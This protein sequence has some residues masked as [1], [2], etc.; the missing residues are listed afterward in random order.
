MAP[1]VNC[2]GLICKLVS[3]RYTEAQTSTVDHA[4]KGVHV[5]PSIQTCNKDHA[6]F[7]KHA[8]VSKPSQ[9]SGVR[10]RVQHV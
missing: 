5:S 8:V 10:Y 2:I 6:S 4:I 3:G 7:D 9:Q 1:S